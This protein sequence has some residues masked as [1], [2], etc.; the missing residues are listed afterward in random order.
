MASSEYLKDLVTQVENLVAQL[1]KRER[2]NNDDEIDGSTWILLTELL[3]AV[4]AALLEDLNDSGKTLP[5][6]VTAVNRRATKEFLE[7][8]QKVKNEIPLLNSALT[9]LR[10]LLPQEPG[11]PRRDR[12]G[13]RRSGGSPP[14]WGQ[15]PSGPAPSRYRSPSKARSGRPSESIA[16]RKDGEFAL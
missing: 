8:G 2:A 16:E 7:P 9:E 10:K 5:A 11:T 4:D 1:E 14:D 15:G 13:E 6:V 3:K 12:P